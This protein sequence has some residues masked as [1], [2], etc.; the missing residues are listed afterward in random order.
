M[1][2]QILGPGCAKCSKLM[3]TAKT[4]AMELG[5]ACDFEKISDVNQIMG[6][7]VMMTP[8]LVVDGV[9]KSVGKVPSLE[10]MKKLLQ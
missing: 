5:I 2:I 1:K 10:E 9:V 3:D 4:A 7:G 8:G 6:F